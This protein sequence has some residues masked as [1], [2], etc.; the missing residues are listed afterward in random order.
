MGMTLGV[1][2]IGIRSPVLLAPYRFAYLCRAAPP[3]WIPRLPNAV[4]QDSRN[5]SMICGFPSPHGPLSSLI[6]VWPLF[7]FRLTGADTV[8]LVLAT[9]PVENAV[10]LVT[11]L[12]VEPGGNVS[13]IARFSSGFAG[14]SR[15]ALSF[16]SSWALS[17]VASRFGS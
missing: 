8:E 15:S 5:A 4:L 16:A 6:S 7:R 2:A 13:W 10:E 14:L 12:N 1:T 9:A 3:S 17:R 11:I